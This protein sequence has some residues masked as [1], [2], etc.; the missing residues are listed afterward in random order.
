MKPFSIP[1]KLIS[2]P[3]SLAALYQ[4]CKKRIWLVCD[5]FLSETEALKQIV[6]GLSQR[7]QVALFTDVK[8]DPTTEDVAKGVSVMEAFE[9]DVVIAYGG[10]SAI[11]LTKA[12]RFVGQKRGYHSGCFIVIP[13]T[14][15]T[16]SEVTN[17]SVISQP[18]RQ[19]KVPLVDDELLPD[20]AILDP[21]QTL[22]VPPAVT[23]NTG[24]DVLT[25]AIEAVVSAKSDDFSNALAEKA[26][27]LVFKYL[28]PAFI[29]GNDIEA[30][31]KLHNASCLA[32]MAFNHAGLGLTHAIAHQ[33]G[34]TL[35][36]PH[37]LANALL[38]TSV[39]EFNRKC[40]KTEATYARLARC[41]G[42]VP[43]GADCKTG[44]D[45]LI[46]ETR[47]L[48]DAVGITEV[49]ARLN[50]IPKNDEHLLLAIANQAQQDITLK[51]NPV[52]P[53]VKEI[54]EIIRAI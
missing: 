42:F 34:A 29:D 50:L 23:A 8:P 2:G 38:L 18:E 37:G 36:I 16:G 15:G 9:P 21:S 28:K 49:G 13:T 54:C 22:T 27:T 12:I 26:I 6:T 19:I 24:I 5:P 4:L 43:R 7:N 20:I 32:G 25:H 51:T 52:R 10:G 53:D 45:A 17:I 40:N 41:L 33:L 48:I 46:H 14:S 47:V 39:M 1:T 30:R 44:A 31:E 35:H 3:N 11:D